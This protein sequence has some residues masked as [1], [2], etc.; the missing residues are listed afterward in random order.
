MNKKRVKII[1]EKI[2]MILMTIAVMVF[3]LGIIFLVSG[4][5]MDIW[6]LLYEGRNFMLLSS[7]CFFT[8]ITLA[9]VNEF[10]KVPENSHGKFVDSAIRKK[11]DEQRAA[12]W[13]NHVDQPE[14]KKDE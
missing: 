5:T 12:D 14:Y 6:D 9:V 1:L 11:L 13:K 3:I 2:E 8:S 7:I 4:W 10:I